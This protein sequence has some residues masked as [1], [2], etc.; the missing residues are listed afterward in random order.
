MMKLSKFSRFSSLFLLIKVMLIFIDS[1][2]KYDT[3]FYVE[4]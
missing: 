3:L 1:E 4:Y 2:V